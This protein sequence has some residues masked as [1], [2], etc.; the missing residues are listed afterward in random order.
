MPAATGPCGTSQLTSA[1]RVPR[2]T[3]LQAVSSS[4]AVTSV[5]VDCGLPPQVGADGIPDGDQVYAGTIGDL[6]GGEIV[7]DDTD[8]LATLALH[9][10]QRGDGHLFH[11]EN[12]SQN[13]HRITRNYTD[14]KPNLLTVRCRNFRV[15]PCASV[16]E[17]VLWG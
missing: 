3:A 11:D 2:R 12:R 6:R 5:S 1:R 13:S 14:K 8:D 10:L 16:A 4:S 17:V 9:L 15:V 7:E